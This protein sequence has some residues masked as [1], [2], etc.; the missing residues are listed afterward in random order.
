MFINLYIAR[1]TYHF[2]L[3]YTCGLTAVIK[4]ICYDMLC[5]AGCFNLSSQAQLLIFI[6]S[7]TDSCAVVTCNTV[8]NSCQVFD[9]SGIVLAYRS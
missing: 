6:S 8:T 1:P 5:Y 3:I 2:I 4:R 9:L 7:T